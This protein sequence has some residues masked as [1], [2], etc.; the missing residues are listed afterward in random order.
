MQLFVSG[1]FFLMI[2]FCI[3]CSKTISHLNQTGTGNLNSMCLC[4]ERVRANLLM[5]TMLRQ[6]GL[7]G[8]QMVWT[9]D[10]EVALQ[11]ARTDKKI[12]AMTSDMFL[13]ILN[14]FI[15][16]TTQELTRMERTKYE[17]LITIHVH[18][19]DIFDDLVG[20]IFL[21]V[22][23]KLLPVLITVIRCSCDIYC[24]TCHC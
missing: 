8:L 12:M 24:Y 5:P 10:S 11:L 14:E 18:Q 2:A 4:V 1:T 9:R 16:V 19:K 23:G 13:D 20:A 22:E 7:L 6:V 21:V 15:E 3:N 17:T